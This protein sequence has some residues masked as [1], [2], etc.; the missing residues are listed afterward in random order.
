MSPATIPYRP[1]SGYDSASATGALTVQ[2]KAQN[3]VLVVNDITIERQ[4]NTISDA[5]PGVTF[6]VKAESKA[7]ET[8]DI[9]RATDANQK[10]ISDWVTAY[11]SLQSTINSVYQICG[12][13]S[14]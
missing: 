1:R 10:A 13:R 4:S 7:D 2:T 14:G 11:N 3:A 12:C 6:T 9:T 8:L 5:L